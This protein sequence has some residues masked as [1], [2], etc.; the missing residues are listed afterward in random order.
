MTRR[1]FVGSFGPVALLALLPAAALAGHHKKHKHHH[2][3]EDEDEGPG[4]GEVTATEQKGGVVTQ[5]KNVVTEQ[6]SVT[7]QKSTVLQG[8]KKP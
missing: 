1:H 4:K 6:R 8:E 2:E 7:E 3:D 5:Q